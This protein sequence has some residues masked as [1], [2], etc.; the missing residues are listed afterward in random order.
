MTLLSPHPHPTLHPCSLRAPPAV[1][2]VRAYAHARPSSSS[3][4]SFARR[5]TVSLQQPADRAEQP[6]GS[7]ISGPASPDNLTSLSP[8]LSYMP[9]SPDRHLT[10]SSP[11]RRHHRRRRRRHHRSYRHHHRR[12]HR[13]ITSS[14]ASAALHAPFA[15]QRCSSPPPV[16]AATPKTVVM[17]TVSSNQMSLCSQSIIHSILYSAPASSVSHSQLLCIHLSYYHCPYESSHFILS[18]CHHHHRC[19]VHTAIT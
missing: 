8:H 5:R 2:T 13:R 16:T 14:T 15:P 6:S 19:Q 9:S 18:H 3:S 7:A 10:S 12:P 17:S 4:S 11:A 1:T